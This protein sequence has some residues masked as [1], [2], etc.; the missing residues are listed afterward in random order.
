MIDQVRKS[1]AVVDGDIYVPF[2]ANTS[3]EDWAETLK[4]GWGIHSSLFMYLLVGFGGWLGGQALLSHRCP[5][6]WV[7]SYF[8]FA[9]VFRFRF[10]VFENK[11]CRFPLSSTV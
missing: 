3:A 10:S 11:I 7:I 6:D 4:V 8:I 1:F 5:R 2:T 9:S